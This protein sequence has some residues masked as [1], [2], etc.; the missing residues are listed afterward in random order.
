MFLPGVLAEYSSSQDQPQADFAV[1]EV[2]PQG[3]TSGDLNASSSD[4]M[5]SN[6]IAS[7]ASTLH[8]E[9]DSAEGEMI[10]FA[11]EVATGTL[12]TILFSTLRG[13][14]WPDGVVLDWV[15]G[16]GETTLNWADT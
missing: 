4:C 16:L 6:R 13:S 8:E 9:A 15:Q 2:L 1:V 7:G 3:K 11:K 10:L 14:V 12:C 5:P